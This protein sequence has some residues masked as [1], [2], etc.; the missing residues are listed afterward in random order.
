MVCSFL[1]NQRYVYS[2][3]LSSHGS[4]TFEDAQAL[5][6]VTNNG[7][8]CSTSRLS[9]ALHMACLSANDDLSTSFVPTTPTRQADQRGT[10]SNVDI[11]G[12]RYL[13]LV[14]VSSVLPSFNATIFSCINNCPT[15]SNHIPIRRHHT[16]CGYILAQKARS[17]YRLFIQYLLA[18]SIIPGETQ[19]M[20]SANSMS[21]DVQRE[22][23]ETEENVARSPNRYQA[24]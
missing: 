24:R 10:C 23:V 13:H 9:I 20:V 16:C 21:E 6:S 19:S 14:Q 1:K 7:E 22:V 2:C 15:S 3:K 8:H 11:P 17:P 5:I 12:D 18:T 4:H